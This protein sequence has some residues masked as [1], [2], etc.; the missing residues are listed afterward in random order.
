MGLEENLLM[1]C[2]II[3]LCFGSKKFRF[4]RASI[5]L[6]LINCDLIAVNSTTIKFNLGHEIVQKEKTIIHHPTH[7]MLQIT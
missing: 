1:C 6:R 7:P 5:N 4:Q 2:T 3:E